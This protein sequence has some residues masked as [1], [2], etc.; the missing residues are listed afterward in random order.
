MGESEERNA[1]GFPRRD[2]FCSTGLAENISGLNDC[3]LLYCKSRF[4]IIRSSAKVFVSIS[5][6]SLHDSVSVDRLEYLEKLAFLK[7]LILLYDRSNV[8]NVVECNIAGMSDKL[9]EEHLTEELLK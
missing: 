6:I 8:C 9:R 7:M 3:K 4:L 2:T 5:S 1:I